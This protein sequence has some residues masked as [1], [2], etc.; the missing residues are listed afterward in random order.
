MSMAIKRG[1]GAQ[2]PVM[3][4]SDARINL[5]ARTAHNLHR[6]KHHEKPSIDASVSMS[7]RAAAHLR[8]LI[9]ENNVAA[10]NNPA[11]TKT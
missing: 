1:A 9:S 5:P 2:P 3:E 7:C 11:P 6:R 4:A 10:I 8:N